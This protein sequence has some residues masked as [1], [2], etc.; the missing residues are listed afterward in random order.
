MTACSYPHTS[1]SSDWSGRLSSSWTG[2]LF[3]HFFI[4]GWSGTSTIDGTDR[5]SVPRPIF[6]HLAQASPMVEP[7]S[8]WVALSLHGPYCSVPSVPMVDPIS[9]PS[10]NLLQMVSKSLLDLTL[11]LHTSFGYFFSFLYSPKVLID[12]LWRF[13]PILAQDSNSTQL[14]LWLHFFLQ[15]N[16]PP[17]AWLLGDPKSSLEPWRIPSLKTL[18]GKPLGT[19]P[20][21]GK[22]VGSSRP[23]DWP[24]SL[25]VLI[26]V[27]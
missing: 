8:V 4:S 23:R 5:L 22:R 3:L 2:A 20:C 13:C 19:K 7:D 21:K 6:A 27:W 1:I 10:P 26:S 11:S 14:L 12:N 24:V 9:A 15:V 18:Q 16:T 17:Q 25:C